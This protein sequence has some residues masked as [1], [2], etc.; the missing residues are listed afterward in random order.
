MPHGKIISERIPYELIKNSLKKYALEI[1]EPFEIKPVGNSS[2]I[3]LKRSSAHLYFADN[4]ESLTTL[5]RYCGTRPM[6]LLPAN[7]EDVFLQLVQK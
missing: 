6:L 3:F 2:F 5:M 4:T 7:L 1:R